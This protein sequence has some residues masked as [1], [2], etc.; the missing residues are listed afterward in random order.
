[1]GKKSVKIQLYEKTRSKE[2]VQAKY[3]DYILDD[4][5]ISCTIEENL[6]ST[7]YF[8][9]AEFYV[10]NEGL[11]THLQEDA[12]LKVKVDYG[13]EIFSIVNVRKTPS[14]VTVFA[15]QITISETLG[16]WLE[17][18]RP[19]NKNGVEALNHMQGYSVG[20]KNLE[21]ESDIQ[22][23][24]TSYFIDKSL[25][26]AIHTAD[27]CFQNRWGGEV[28][29]RGY[30][31][32]INYKIGSETAIQIRS[33]KNLTGF[34][35]TTNIDE[36]VTR[37]KPKGFNGITTEDYIDSPLIN[38][39]KYIRTQ[40][41]EYSHVKLASDIEEGSEPGEGDLVF[42]NL[43]EAQAKL[44][45]L[46]L[47]EYLN[48]IDVLRAEY[49]INFID[50]SMTE[51]Y[52]NYAQA[53]LIQ[54]GDSINVYEEK[55]NINITVRAISRKYNVMAQR[56]IEMNL[57]NTFDVDNAP[58]IEEVKSRLDEVTQNV[59]YMSAFYAKKSDLEATNEAVAE[60]QA[61]KAD[62]SSLDAISAEMA[63]LQSN[64]ADK[65]ALNS[66][67]NT[68]N[69]KADQSALNT[70]NSN[71]DTLSSEVDTL[72]TQT[73][74][75][76]E[77][78]TQLNTKVDNISGAIGGDFSAIVERVEA[79]EG[80]ITTLD[81]RLD[82]LEPKVNT[83]ITN[84]QNLTSSVNTNTTNIAAAQ[85]SITTL[86]N[87]LGTTNTELNSVSDK[88]GWIIESGTS[89]SN[90]VLS[91]DFINEISE[92][93]NIDDSQY[94]KKNDI[95][96]KLKLT[97]S[98]NDISLVFDGEVLSVI[99]IELNGDNGDSGDETTSYYIEYIVDNTSTNAL[100]SGSADYKYGLPRIYSDSST[101][102]YDGYEAIE[103][104]L[105][106]GTTTTDV[107]TTCDQISKVKLW[108]PEATTGI[109][110]AVGSSDT[111][112]VKTVN[113]FNASNLTSIS[114]Y[115][116]KSLTT[117]DASDW[118]VSNVTSLRNMFYGCSSLT[119]LDASD[120]NTSNVTTAETMFYGCTNLTSL[121]LSNWDVSGLTS[122]YRTFRLCT[123][124]TAL[125][126]SS[127][128]NAN[129]IT[130]MNQT[131]YYCSKLTSLDLS[132]WDVSKVTI[133]SSAFTSCSALTD[134]KA[135]KNISVAVSFSPCT[136]LTHDSLM[137]IINNLATVTSSK[138][139]TL[140]STNLEKLTDAEK[141]I[142][143]NKGW[144]LA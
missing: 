73:Q 143:T 66:L 103:I 65:S 68:V 112:V 137:S 8:L 16:S 80:N 56:V 113:Y 115:F 23:E 40:V 9:D 19:E 129:N 34:E 45:E 133:M 114:F 101:Y 82:T 46:A 38:E 10:D 84:I 126:L 22:E 27:N 120:W 61:T 93:I 39:Y 121:D 3:G 122:M 75:L 128:K 117:L 15:R 59:D 79:A 108:Y 140:G 88:V 53:E 99:T 62:A 97:M 37:I 72:E 78:Y 26:A 11:Y 138:T 77:Q 6:L 52:K 96:S 13:E 105:L 116:C 130:T 98:G 21:F 107:T 30:K 43:E 50:L 127:W 110:F 131:F 17:D 28:R 139:L 125:D 90:M 69:K 44:T 104:T 36:V 20:K 86:T 81:E 87:E 7:E 35:A 95:I 58:N 100:N 134:F 111:S 25:Y 47:L 54:L 102:S 2:Q 4:I 29:R 60:L 118:N 144:T 12:V 71:L 123:A 91:N 31:L 92:N 41:M 124:L 142:A 74:N 94:V 106:D 55:H 136:N 48:L 135:P 89:S 141:A 63:T 67:T 32:I 42:N 57:S 5:C 24:F 132:S 109:S 51:E 70:T 49:T 64:K 14:K 33:G 18:V 1:M 83:N 76:Q 119:S 85:G